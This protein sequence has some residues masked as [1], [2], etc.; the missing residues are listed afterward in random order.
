MMARGLCC[1][2][3]LLSLTLTVDA[4]ENAFR[5][6]GAPGKAWANIFASVGLAETQSQDAGIVI[7]GGAAASDVATLA[8]NR[9][10]ILEGTGPAASKLGIESKSAE[11]VVRQICDKHAPRIQVFWKEAVQVPLVSLPGDFEVF[12]WEKWKNAPVLAGKRTAHGAILWTASD[13]GQTGMERYPY[14]LQSL[15]DLG[16]QPAL[17]ATNLWAF[18]DSSYRI[19]ADVD[20][21]AKRWRNAGIGVL[22]VAAWHNMESDTTRKTST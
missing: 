16:F 13:P 8:Q 19:R 11:I 1:V 17:R 20:Y 4:A 2:L 6:E 10:V 12:A 18:F 22:H 3:T 7:A 14:L 9:F 5:F 15:L 21:L